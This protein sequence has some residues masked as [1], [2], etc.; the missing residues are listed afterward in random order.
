MLRP[1][2]D[3]QIDIIN[4]STLQVASINP[5][6]MKIFLYYLDLAITANCISENNCLAL[7]GFDLNTVHKIR[8]QRE[9]ISTVLEFET[10]TAG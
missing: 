10:R 7:D 2:Q 4:I 6:N 3:G 5:G 1:V 8:Q 9:K